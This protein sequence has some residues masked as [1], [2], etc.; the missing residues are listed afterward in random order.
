MPAA[1]VLRRPD[2]SIRAGAA[3]SSRIPTGPGT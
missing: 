3:R 1:E 2:I